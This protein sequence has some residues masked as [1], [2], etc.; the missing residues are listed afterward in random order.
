MALRYG[1]ICSS[2]N[3]G[4]SPLPMTASNSAC[5]LVWTSGK[6]TIARENPSTDTVY[7][8]VHIIFFCI[9]IC[10][11]WRHHKSGIYI[12]VGLQSRPQNEHNP[13]WYN[14]QYYTIWRLVALKGASTIAIICF[15][16]SWA[17][18][19]NPAPGN[20]E[21]ICFTSTSYTVSAIITCLY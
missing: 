11:T 16:H 18:I 6:Y 20:Y 19:W 2:E 15:R 4:K 5:A 7:S 10:K 13:T 14:K 17:L 21:G 9:Q 12:A 3:S 1:R 8:V